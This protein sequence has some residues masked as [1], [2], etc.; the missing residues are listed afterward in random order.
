MESFK[1]KDGED[2]QGR[3]KVC[4]PVCQ[5]ATDIRFHRSHCSVRRWVGESPAAGIKESPSTDFSLSGSP[6]SW[7]S[8][9]SA[10]KTRT[11]LTP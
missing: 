10:V 4:G 9:A 5:G 11:N 7:W 2:V 6:L 8:D 1:G 3:N